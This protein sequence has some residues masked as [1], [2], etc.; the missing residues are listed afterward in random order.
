MNYLNSEKF[1]KKKLIPSSWI[2]MKLKYLTTIS[3]NISNNPNNEKILSLTKNGIKVRSI[4]SN[5][6]QIAESYDKYILV[7][8]TDICMNPMDLLSGWVD[9]SNYK[10]LISP[11]YYTIRVNKNFDVNFIKF[12]LQS[13]YY[14]K[15]F[16]TLGKGVASHDN[17]GRWSLPLSE[18]NNIIIY[19]PKSKTEQK[20]ISSYIDNEVKKINEL[21]KQVEKKQ[22]FLNEYFETLVYNL[23]TKGI[24]KGEKIKPTKN[25]SVKNI[26]ITWSVKKLKYVIKKILDNRGKTPPYTQEGVPM[27]EIPNIT[28]G[29]KSPN[30]EFKKFVE[31]NLVK[32]FERDRIQKNDILIST[33]GAT[34]G[35]VVIIEKDPNYFICQN[36]VGLRFKDEIDPNYFYYFLSSKFFKNSLERINKSNTIDNLKVSIFVNVPSLIPPITE[37]IKISKILDK[38]II[39]F[40]KKIKLVNLKLKLLNEKKKSLICSII[41]GTYKIL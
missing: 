20:L 13:N 19:L 18:F 31:P 6:G 38:K 4:D 36:I 35:K 5:Q 15:N 1:Y 24:E 33:V 39:E 26:P 2:R 28:K 7:N 21:I 12:F 16:F 10:G 29:S 37:Q 30:L 22:L 23:V 17:F 9:I 11:A 32:A 34:A 25:L 8:E 3:E 14:R 41:T 40:E 27:F